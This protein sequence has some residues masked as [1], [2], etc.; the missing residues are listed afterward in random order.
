MV[1]AKNTIISKVIKN[2]NKY[3]IIKKNLTNNKDKGKNNNIDINLK[4]ICIN[5]CR[6]KICK[7]N[8]CKQGHEESLNL[9]TNEEK[10]E[11][12][13]YIKIKFPPPDARLKN[14]CMSYLKS[15]PCKKQI[16]GKIFLSSSIL[17]LSI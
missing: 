8:N 2:D 15:N 1:N 13:D 9:L 17:S 10:L 7:L 4:G 12:D 3:S 11:L 14:I 5:Y 16:L 6:N